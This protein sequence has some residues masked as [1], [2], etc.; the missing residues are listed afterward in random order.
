MLWFSNEGILGLIFGTT[1][2]RRTSVTLL[3]LGQILIALSV[4]GCA[5]LQ[6]GPVRPNPIASDTEWLLPY[7]TVSQGQ[8]LTPEVRNNIITTR[9]YL[10]DLEYHKYETRMIREL[11]QEGLAAT[12]AN[13]GLTGAASLIPVAQTDRLLAGIATGVTGLDKAYTEKELMNN[14]MQQLQIQMRTDRKTQA[15]KMFAKM[16]QSDSYG[17]PIVDGNGNRKPTDTTTYTL[18]MALADTDSYYQAGTISSALVG[19]YKTTSNAEQKADCSKNAAGP[20]GTA[21]NNAASSG[22]QLATP[23]TTSQQQTAKAA[24]TAAASTTTTTTVCQ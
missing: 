8:P 11:Q 17:N 6:G 3:N 20:H 10:I 18:A 9:M 4:C 1:R 14:T 13:L 12:V 19:L 22:G 15:S 7:T 5:S 16:W 2:R 23:T 24:R 21:V